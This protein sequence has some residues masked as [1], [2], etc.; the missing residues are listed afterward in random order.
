MS[1]QTKKDSTTT[2]TDEFNKPS[3]IILDSA[4]NP[5]Q[6][7][8]SQSSIRFS[9]VEMGKTASSKKGLKKNKS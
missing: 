8:E 4:V 5:I 1:S 7:D 9:D 2:E 3:V 6:R